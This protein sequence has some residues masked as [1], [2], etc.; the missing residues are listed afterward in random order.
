MGDG[1]L[2]GIMD[3]KGKA[4]ANTIIISPK[5]PP[6]EMRTIRFK[7][8]IN[9][10]IDLPDMEWQPAES[11]GVPGPGKPMT[12][13]TPFGVIWIKSKNCIQIS[14]VKKPDH[15]EHLEKFVYNV[16]F[17]KE[18]RSFTDWLKEQDRKFEADLLG[19]DYE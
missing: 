13:K 6:Y 11:R 3:W 17:R 5:A 19:K 1:L 4:D 15:M 12:I 18:R 14:H 8:P 9:L 7:E 16:L 10:N 2:G